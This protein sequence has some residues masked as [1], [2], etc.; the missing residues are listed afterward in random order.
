MGA[1]SI[2]EQ[3]NT[4]FKALGDGAPSSQDPGVKV[5]SVLLPQTQESRFQPQPPPGPQSLLLQ[6]STRL[7]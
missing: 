6:A 2:W 3:R 1:A 7:S 5:P 4:G